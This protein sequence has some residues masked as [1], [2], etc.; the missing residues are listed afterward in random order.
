M[1]TDNMEQLD[2]TYDSNYYV[3][4]ARIEV[5]ILIILPLPRPRREN[6]VMKKTSKIIVTIM[7]LFTMVLSTIAAP[8]TTEAAS[9]K[10]AKVTISSVT[11][12][13]NKAKITVKFKSVKKATGYQV[14][15][16]KSTSK[17]YTVKTTKKTSYTI[18]ASNT[19]TYNIKVRAYH[20][21]NG[22]TYYG[23]WSA[24]KTVNKH[25]HN[26]KPVYKT[27]VDQEAY[28][29]QVPTGEY[30]TKTEKRMYASA[31]AKN[32]ET[33]M[34]TDYVCDIDITGMNAADAKA[35]V[36]SMG[37]RIGNVWSDYVTVTD[38]DNPIYKTVHHDAVTHK[39]LTGYKCSCGKTKSK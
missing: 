3:V 16:K 12:N 34:Y 32:P 25:T 24:I 39:E 29:E 13:I 31:Y 11:R 36:E 27:V 30:Q 37:Y 33:G 5:Y 38:Y 19:A 10:P 8:V 17:K 4:S 22:K 9:P 21:S 18:K 14:A 2:M 15:Y 1:I 6:T 28:D 35:Y 23:N 20:K 26:W 7:L